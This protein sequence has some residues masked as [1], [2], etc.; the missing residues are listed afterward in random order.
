[1]ADALTGG[2]MRACWLIQRGLSRGG[3]VDEVAS[4]VPEDHRAASPRL[5]LL[6]DLGAAEDVVQ[7]AF[8]PSATPVAQRYGIGE[9]QEAVLAPLTAAQRRQFINLLSRLT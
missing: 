6:G 7:D 1:M 2:W 8:T 3:D 4:R 5:G 9:I